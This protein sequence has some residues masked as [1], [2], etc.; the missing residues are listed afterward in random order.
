MSERLKKIRDASHLLPDPGGEV[1][2][3]L[4]TEIEILREELHQRDKYVDEYIG[5]LDRVIQRNAYRS[6]RWVTL[7]DQQNQLIAVRDESLRIHKGLH[8]RSV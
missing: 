6:Y 8:P 3:D 1:V 5:R 2:R 7:A 4:I